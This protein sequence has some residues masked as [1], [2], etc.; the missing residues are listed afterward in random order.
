MPNFRPLKNHMLYCL[1]KLIACYH[2][3]PPFLDA[4]CGTGFLSLHLASKGWEGKALDFSPAAIAQTH[5]LLTKFP[6]IEVE[7]K[8][9]FDETA[10]YRTIFL[11]DILEHLEDDVAALEKAA[12]LLPPG[13]HLLLSL[14]SNPREWRWDDEFYGHF[15]RYTV[16]EARTKIRQAGLKPLVLWD[17]SYPIFWAMRRIYTK[18]K[19]TPKR[20]QK[21][22]RQA[23]TKASSLTNAWSFPLFSSLLNRSTPIW[24]TFSRLQYLFFKQQ[25]SKGHVI[26]LLAIKPKELPCN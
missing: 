15:R 2:L 23:K 20:D 7:E 10:I 6:Q 8:S 11:W 16:T 3:S 9:F 24:R 25:L 17:V 12:A 4:G 5:R 18:L 22:S 26:L 14:P 13:G 21:R 1:D 19:P